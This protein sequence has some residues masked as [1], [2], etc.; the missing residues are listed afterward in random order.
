MTE[1]SG[2]QILLSTL[3]GILAGTGS[4]LFGIGGGVI[5]VPALIYLFKFS[6][7]TAS[8]T[9]LIAMLL[10]VGA[11]GAYQY[12]SEGKISIFHI[13]LGL[14]VGLGMFFGGFLG[15]KLALHLSPSVMKKCFSIFLFIISIKVWFSSF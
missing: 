15:A 7:T 1:I 8:G 11:L 2:M 12:F 9:S 13:K 4:G 6:Q 14:L 3:V 10:P 5:I